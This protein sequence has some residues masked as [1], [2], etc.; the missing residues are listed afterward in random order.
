M[1]NVIQTK[2]PKE[3]FTKVLDMC[4]LGVVEKGKIK[5][6]IIGILNK[7]LTLRMTRV[8]SPTSSSSG[9]GGKGRFGAP[10]DDEGP[11]QYITI[12]YKLIFF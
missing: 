3:I 7:G 10:P 2:S 1:H 12:R 4:I 11:N 8:L 5:S 9:V 6:A